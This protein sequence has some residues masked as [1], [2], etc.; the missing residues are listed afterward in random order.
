MIS[1]VAPAFHEGQTSAAFVAAITPVLGLQTLVVG[2]NA[3]GYASLLIVTLF[4]GGMILLSNGVQG[5][6]IA[7]I[8]EAKGR[9]L[10]G[11]AKTWGID[12]AAI[13]PGTSAHE[14]SRDVAS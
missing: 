13:H 10:F 9:T 5:E 3:P 11:V 7:R 2:A 1:V 12:D 4:L 8:F 14:Q 6:Y